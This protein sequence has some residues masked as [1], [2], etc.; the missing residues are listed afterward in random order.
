MEIRRTEGRM[1]GREVYDY[2]RWQDYYGR[3]GV[4]GLAGNDTLGDLCIAHEYLLWAVMPERGSS[5][6]RATT[7]Y[8]VRASLS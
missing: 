8:E 7:L 2:E 3:L 1:M 5:V 6:I 4:R